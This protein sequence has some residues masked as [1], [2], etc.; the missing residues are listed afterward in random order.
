MM[1]IWL[2]CENHFPAQPLGIAKTHAEIDKL[3]IEH[4]RTAHKVDFKATIE[5]YKALRG[6]QA[7]IKEID[8]DARFG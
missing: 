8:L 4:Q 5:A 3:V 6:A 2:V 7:L 1:K